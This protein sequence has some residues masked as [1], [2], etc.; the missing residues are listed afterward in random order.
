MQRFKP[1]PRN[2]FEA[3][4]WAEAFLRSTDCN[5]QH[6]VGTAVSAATGQC[7]IPTSSAHAAASNALVRASRSKSLTV[8]GYGCALCGAH[9]FLR[10]EID[11]N[12]QN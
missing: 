3:K 4:L 8:S 7:A 6:G 12:G 5:V 2:C 10:D 9:L 11:C 1:E